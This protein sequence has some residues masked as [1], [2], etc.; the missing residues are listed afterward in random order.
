MRAADEFAWRQVTSRAQGADLVNQFVLDV[1]RAPKP[2]E[3]GFNPLPHQLADEMTTSANE[4]SESL[5]ASMR[6]LLENAY[7]QRN[8]ET[9]ADRLGTLLT[10]QELIH[11]SYFGQ[12]AVAKMI[13]AHI[14]QCATPGGRLPTAFEP[15]RA[16][17]ASNRATRPLPPRGALEFVTALVLLI[18]PAF[19]LWVSV[20]TTA[21]AVIMPYTAAF[22]LESI[23]D[24]VMER[25]VLA[26]GN[27]G[28]LAALLV[29]LE[30]KGIVAD[31][32]QTLDRIPHGQH[33]R[34]AATRLA[35]AYGRSGRIKDIQRLLDRKEEPD[36]QKSEY[37]ARIRLLAFIGNSTRHVAGAQGVQGYGVQGVSRSQSPPQGLAPVQASS[38][39]YDPAFL[40][41]INS[42]LDDLPGTTSLS[43]IVQRDLNRLVVMQMALSGQV[44][45]GQKI[46]DFAKGQGAYS[47]E[48][49]CRFAAALGAG[50][51]VKSPETNLSSLVDQCPASRR[52]SRRAEWQANLRRH[53]ATEVLLARKVSGL[54]AYAKAND[55][56]SLSQDEI[57]DALFTAKDKDDLATKVLE[58]LPDILLLE[59]NL[60]PEQLALVNRNNSWAA[61]LARNYVGPIAMLSRRAFELEATQLSNA[62]LDLLVRQS[63]AWGSPE[64]SDV[65][66][67]VEALAACGRLD[68]ARQLFL[69][70]VEY[71]GSKTPEANESPTKVVEER[72]TTLSILVAAA[73]RLADTSSVA[74]FADELLHIAVEEPTA[75]TGELISGTVMPIWK[76]DPARGKALLANAM[77]YTPLLGNDKSR[78]RVMGILAGALTQTGAVRRARLTALQIGNTDWA[79]KALLDVVKHAD[80][81]NSYDFRELGSSALLMQKISEEDQG[82]VLDNL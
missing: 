23:K 27:G 74:K 72:L 52:G 4:H 6:A 47:A 49:V 80:L 19:T 76:A 56:R 54:H 69:K 51:A 67:L 37:T 18:L 34:Q 7:D 20:R 13:A 12:P 8:T 42:Y 48:E 35:Y 60:T 53:V 61:R 65:A 14:D 41:L 5:V 25:R 40:G 1:G 75:E 33:R 28:K 46:L 36:R 2:L 73:S 31:P 45:R 24:Y 43:Y 57:E 68:Q 30:A 29:G 64:Q 59:R 81:L 82:E 39:D 16:D 38:N 9:I 50:R 66:S 15:C 79:L 10:F 17:L 22:Q 77:D 58:L 55:F 3:P 71:I 62:L 63:A 44:D 26:A 32:I 11:T 78:N 21:D 70:Y